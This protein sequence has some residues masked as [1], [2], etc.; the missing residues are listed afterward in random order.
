MPGF[1]TPHACSSTINID[2]GTAC[3]HRARPSP[4]WYPQSASLC[5]ASQYIPRQ[6]FKV[7]R[8]LS[9]PVAH[10]RVDPV[11]A[12][13]EAPELHFLAILNLL[14]IAVAPLERHL[15]VCICIHQYIE[16]A[17]PIEHGQEGDRRCNLAEDRLDFRL[18]LLFRLLG[19]CLSPALVLV[20]RELSLGWGSHLLWSPILLIGCSL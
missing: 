16:G 18:D 20:S 1:Q 8:R 12:R 17:I 4:T 13:A 5:S 7:P 15:R 11:V 10:K 3:S 6:N 19:C 14:R 2:S 9:V